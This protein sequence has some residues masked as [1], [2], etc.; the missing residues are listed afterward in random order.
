[1][2]LKIAQVGEPVLRQK[3]RQIAADEINTPSVQQLIEFMRETMHD[4]PGVGLAAPQ[5]GQSLQLIVIED[6]QEYID[7]LSETEAKERGRVPV[8]FQVLINPILTAKTHANAEFHEGCLSFAGFV[9]LVPRLTSVKV[10]GLNEK[11][12]PVVI[13]AD[14]WYARILQHEID[15]LHG[16]LCIDHMKL[17]SLT[18]YENYQKFWR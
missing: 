15:H 6:R 13:E 8:P 2:K 14:G 17:H 4:A 16:V 5:I 10:E 18:T 3:A 9:G 11:G 7:R 12:Q 1:M